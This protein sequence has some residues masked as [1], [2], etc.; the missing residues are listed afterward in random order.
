[1]KQA[2]HLDLTE[3]EIQDR[4]ISITE[5]DLLVRGP[6]DLQFRGLNDGT[7]NLILRSRFEQE[8]NEFI[9]DIREEFVVK[10]AELQHENRRLRGMLNHLPGRLAENSL[11]NARHPAR[12]NHQAEKFS[13]SLR[14]SVYQA[15]GLW[16]STALY[17]RRQPGR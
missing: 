8:I 17:T 16:S 7:L 3:Y 13:C 11:A 15:R 6:S 1:M 10:I 12:G 5:S 9:P 4:L 2:L 14:L